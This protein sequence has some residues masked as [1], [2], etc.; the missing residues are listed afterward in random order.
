MHKDSVAIPNIPEA[1]T[2]KSTWSVSATPCTAA[3]LF[4]SILSLAA[5][6]E[7]TVVKER[8]SLVLAA[9]V[10]AKLRPKVQGIH[11]SWARVH[12]P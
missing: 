8:D 9:T 12:H 6:M 7:N 1:L 3:T 11:E 4:I 2:H 5:A 10:K